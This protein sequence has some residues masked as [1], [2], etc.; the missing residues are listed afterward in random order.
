MTRRRTRQTVAT[1]APTEATTALLPTSSLARSLS[2]ST[3]VT[4]KTARPVTWVTT[5][6]MP[7]K[8][9]LSVSISPRTSTRISAAVAKTP[10]GVVRTMTASGRGLPT[11]RRS[12]SPTTLPADLSP[13]AS[14][15]TNSPTRE[16]SAGTCARVSASL[17]AM[18]L[19]TTPGPSAT[20]S[21]GSP[22]TPC[23]DARTE[24]ALASDYNPHTYL[25]D[26]LYFSQNKP[27]PRQTIK[28]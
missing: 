5:R 22:P 12:G 16:E 2:P 4:K 6:T 23:A 14:L 24:Y 10:Q 21:A 8:S 11:I 28:K 20:P 27:S 1:T 3:C 19:A 17:A 15:T 7:A 9:S 18:S 13:C 26:R 25:I